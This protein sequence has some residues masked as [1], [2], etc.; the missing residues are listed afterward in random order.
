MEAAHFVNHGRQRLALDQLHGVVVDAAFA[1]DAVHRHDV[2]VVQHRRRLGLAEAGPAG[3]GEIAEREEW[4]NA[5]PAQFAA[6]A[7]E[8]VEAV[9]RLLKEQQKS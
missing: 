4:R 2:R 6:P 3:I 5:R 7:S 8:M 1:A 9:K